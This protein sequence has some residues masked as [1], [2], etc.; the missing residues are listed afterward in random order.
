VED[1]AGLNSGP[2]CDRHGSQGKQWVHIKLLPVSRINVKLCAGVPSA[3]RV[4][5]SPSPGETGML[6]SLDS[7]L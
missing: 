3:N 4:R 2:I 1:T 7:L 5:N 6:N